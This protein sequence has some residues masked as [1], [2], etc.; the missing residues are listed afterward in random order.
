MSGEPHGRGPRRVHHHLLVALFY[1]ATVA[2][3][4]SER[5]VS[6]CAAAVVVGGFFA[7]M[8]GILQRVSGTQKLYWALKPEDTSAFFGPYR[9]RNHFAT[10]AGICLFTGVAL[11][12]ARHNLIDSASSKWRDN[13]RRDII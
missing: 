7:S 13:I 1:L 8:L 4:R 5:D 11:V 2:S 10:Y 9:S 3:V 12:L 6:R